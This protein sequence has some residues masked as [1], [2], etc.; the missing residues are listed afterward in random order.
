MAVCRGRLEVLGRV[1]AEREQ[2]RLGHMSL[3]ASESGGLLLAFVS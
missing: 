3:L 1:Q 2:R